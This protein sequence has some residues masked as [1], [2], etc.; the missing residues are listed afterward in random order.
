[1]AVFA[2]CEQAAGDIVAARL[3]E[4]VFHARLEHSATAWE[5][6]FPLF[7]RRV[8]TVIAIALFST[9]R[10]A[11]EEQT[12]P[13]AA[14]AAPAILRELSPVELFAVLPAELG[15]SS[16]RVELCVRIPLIRFRVA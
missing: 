1:M 5:M 10:R 11:A 16:A 15:E 8:Q 7:I 6:E 13:E 12:P 14:A 3:W 4:A 2:T 9:H